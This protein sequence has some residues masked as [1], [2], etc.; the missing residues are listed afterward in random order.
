PAVIYCGPRTVRGKWP[1]DCYVFLVG[2]GAVQMDLLSP[3]WWQANW[4]NIAVTTALTLIIDWLFHRF[5][6]KAMRPSYSVVSNNLVNKIRSRF[7]NL[8]IK[9]HGHGGP[10]EPVTV[11][12]VAIWNAGAETLDK[13]HLVKGYPL[14]IHVKEGCQIVDAEVVARTDAEN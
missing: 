5:G 2:G 8:E 10:L 7:P 13:D 11:S 9:Y 12:K 4:A 1:V 3:V 6:R 14:T